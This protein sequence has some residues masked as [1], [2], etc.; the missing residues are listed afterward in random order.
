MHMELVSAVWV[1]VVIVGGAVMFYRTH[2]GLTTSRLD[3]PRG[4]LYLRL[5]RS[6]RLSMSFNQSLGSGARTVGS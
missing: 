4:R 5:R 1:F 2:T 3:G 6:R